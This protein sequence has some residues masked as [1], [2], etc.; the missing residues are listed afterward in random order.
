[1]A[2]GL[3][4]C[5]RMRPCSTQRAGVRSFRPLPRIVS[6]TPATTPLRFANSSTILARGLKHAAE[7]GELLLKGRSLAIWRKALTDGPPEALDVTL[8]PPPVIWRRKLQDVR[9][10]GVIALTFEEAGLPDQR[11]WAE[12]PFGDDFRARNL[13]AE[14]R[15][16]L[17][18]DPSAP[19]VIPGTNLRIGGSIDRLDLS[20]IPL[21]CPHV[22]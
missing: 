1:M 15:S 16:R 14:Q 22:A 11:S 19:V 12:I 7:I 9:A 4:L 13:T 5:Q 10:L 8:T 20:R 6:V 2:I 17:P 18:W 21:V 3:R